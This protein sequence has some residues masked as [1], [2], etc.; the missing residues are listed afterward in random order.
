MS[1]LAEWTEFTIRLPQGNQDQTNRRN[2][3]VALAKR[4]GEKRKALKRGAVLRWRR[5][6]ELPLLQGHS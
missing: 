4:T 3:T 5:P 1:L 2:K 6:Y